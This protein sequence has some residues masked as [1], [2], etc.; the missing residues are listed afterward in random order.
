M[1]IAEQ[2]IQNMD[3]QQYSQNA[4]TRSNPSPEPIIIDRETG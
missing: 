4:K 3:R 2:P 1:S